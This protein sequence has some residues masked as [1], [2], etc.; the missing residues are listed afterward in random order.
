MAET[1][2]GPAAPGGP[3]GPGQCPCPPS[4]E[5]PA[6]SGGLPHRWYPRPSWGGWGCRLEEAQSKDE[7]WSRDLRGG[8][9]PTWLPGPR[10]ALGLPGWEGGLGTHLR[11]HLG[12]GGESKQCRVLARFWQNRYACLPQAHYTPTP[13]PATT[14]PPHVTPP[15]PPPATHTP[16]P[17]LEPPLAPARATGLSCF[18]PP[19]VKTHFQTRVL[20]QVIT[21]SVIFWREREGRGKKEN[22]GWC[23]PSQVS[24]RVACFS[25]RVR[26]KFALILC[27]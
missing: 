1:L 17:S 12:G 24:G 16:A 2:K 3:W 23:N 26:E 21:A 9:A 18:R 4:Q 6:A 20:C 14:L 11:V 25:Q 27:P 19:S 7:D 8:A 22:S 15:H 10:A 13:N 5:G